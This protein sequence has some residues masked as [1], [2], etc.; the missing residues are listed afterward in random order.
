MEPIAFNAF[1][2]NSSLSVNGDFMHF[3]MLIDC[4]ISEPSSPEFLDNYSTLGKTKKEFII[5]CKEMY[6]NDAR[7]L[8]KV[9]EF[10]DSYTPESALYWYTQDSFVYKL[11]NRAIRMNDTRLILIFRFFMIDIH[12][13]LAEQCHEPIAQENRGGALPKYYVYR[14]QMMSKDE[15]DNLRKSLNNIICMKS[16]LST[17]LNREY[18]LFVLGESDERIQPPLVRVL[19]KI[20]L[21]NDSMS[22]NVDRPFANITAHSHFGDAEEEVLFMSGS[23]FRVVEVRRGEN[24]IWYVCLATLVNFDNPLDNEHE[25]GKLYTRMKNHFI[26]PLLNPRSDLGLLLYQ[27][28]EFNLAQVHFERLLQHLTQLVYVPDGI[29]DKEE[30]TY[31]S[32]IKH[33]TEGFLG[34]LKDVNYACRTSDK[35]QDFENGKEDFMLTCHY[36]LGRIKH[37]KGLF[38]RSIVHYQHVLKRVRPYYVTHEQPKNSVHHVLS[39]LCYS[40]LGA[41]YESNRDFKLACDSY[42]IALHMFEQAH[43]GI[44]DM[45]PF[46]SDSTHIYK[47]H[48]LLGLGNVSLITRN[49]E[50]ADI[51][52]RAAL[53]LFDTYLPRGHPNHSHARQKMAKITQIYRRDPTNALEDYK[54]CLENYLRSLPSNHVDIARVYKDMACSCEQLPNELENALEYA[55]KA[56]NILDEH[57]PKEHADNIETSMIIER[58]QGQLPS[59]N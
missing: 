25:Y 17:S 19:I 11:L 15:L 1:N 16:F 21:G 18:T 41:I 32:P 6:K 58:I 59:K 29:E 49:Y 52:Y 20:D 37:E 8:V 24:G 46:S 40:G 14:A 28:G 53:S 55:M 35:L 7:T 26:H 27:S 4:L 36:M 30:L 42:T 31:P 3:Q 47:A 12:K 13:Q 54:D 2:E 43:G 38:D 23:C 44:I 39:A 45:Y 5:A 48:C 22:G 50:Q 34:F 33:K 10:E 57:L 56:A 9:K 51:Q